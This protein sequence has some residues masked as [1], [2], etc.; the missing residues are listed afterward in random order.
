LENIKTNLNFGSFVEKKKNLIKN[1]NKKFERNLN[2][3]DQK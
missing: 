1:S 2:E 3:G